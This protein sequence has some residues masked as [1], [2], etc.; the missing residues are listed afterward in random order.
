MMRLLIRILFSVV[1]C[2]IRRLI[3]SVRKILWTVVA[4]IR[5]FL[6]LMSDFVY[7]LIYKG[8]LEILP[9]IDSSILLEPVHSLASQIRTGKVFLWKKIYRT[10]K[11]SIALEKIP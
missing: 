10:G 2:L 11:S 1:V 7:G 4:A 3:M 8:H 5:A 6:D 9:P